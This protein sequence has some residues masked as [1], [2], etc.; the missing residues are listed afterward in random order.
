MLSPHEFA[1]LVLVSDS[2]DATALDGAD[3]EALLACQ[4][5]TLERRGPNHSRAQ[6]T[7]QGYA[8]LKALGHTCTKR[9]RATLVS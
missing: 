1:T 7:I 6:V 8:F 5:I 4:L 3:M 9:S 2:A